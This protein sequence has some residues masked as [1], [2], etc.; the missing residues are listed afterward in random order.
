MSWPDGWTAWGVDERGQRVELADGPR[1]RMCGN[2]VVS[3]VAEWIGRRIV[4]A[5]RAAYADAKEAAA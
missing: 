1:Y 2:G 3:T 4:A 5:D